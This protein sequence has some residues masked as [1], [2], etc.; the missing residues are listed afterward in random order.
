MIRLIPPVAVPF[1]PRAIAASLA[2]TGGAVGGRFRE[3]LA[4]RFGAAQV[5][6]AG[7]G[8][9]ALAA[10][11]RTARRADRAEVL[12]PAYTCWS[13]PA[14]AVAAGLRVRLY[15]VDPA[16]F[17]PAED[18]A[19]AAGPETVAV[20]LADLLSEAAG[21][22]DCARAIAASLPECLLVE[23]RAQSWPA[24]ASS[25][26]V[27]LLSFSRGKPLPLGHGG[28]LLSSDPRPPVGL[29]GP[30]VGGAGVVALALV[31]ALGHPMVF[32]LPASIPA[33]GIGATVYNPAIDAA[34]PFRAWQER[35]GARLLPRMEMLQGRRAA[36]A[37]RLAEVVAG[38]RGWAVGPWSG[39]PIRLPVFAPDR[40]ARDAAVER[41]R[42]LGVTASALYPGT[43]LDIPALRD[44][45]APPP[46]SV[47]GAREIADR[48]LALPVYPTLSERDVARIGAAFATVAGSGR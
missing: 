44:H 9:A 22:E 38:C 4:E 8:R 15:D 13:V 37:A 18:L 47:T 27:T 3:G 14:A 1:G 6:L 31:A 2:G 48:L 36:H 35:L 28:A 43:L 23:D 33:L 25:S 29:P 41:L 17:L 10:V 32:R 40:A 39:G 42:R 30:A 11:L 45:L 24:R 7:S 20:V 34:R 12:V 46:A 5:Q 21:F 19:R 26:G 16:T